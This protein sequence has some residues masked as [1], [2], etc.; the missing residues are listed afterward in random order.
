MGLNSNLRAF[1]PVNAVLRDGKIE[2]SWRK[3]RGFI[4][5][6]ADFS[7]MPMSDTRI[8]SVLLCSQLIVCIDWCC[9]LV[10]WMSLLRVSLKTWQLHT[11][12]KSSVFDFFYSPS[13]ILA[14]V[15][16]QSTETN[17]TLRA[18]LNMPVTEQ[19]VKMSSMTRRVGNR[20]Q[21][22]RRAGDSSNTH[23]FWHTVQRGKLI[24]R[25]LDSW[26]KGCEFQS[27]QERRDNFLVQS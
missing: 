1:Q 26:S 4:E 16:V 25:A 14:S 22:T 6:S 12:P 2:S 3:R 9:W 5:L 21:K 24:G 11:I 27:R 20:M 18:A 7:V 10:F 23:W 13:L 19:M 8:F 15:E 17:N